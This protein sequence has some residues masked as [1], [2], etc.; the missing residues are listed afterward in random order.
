MLRDVAIDHVLHARGFAEALPRRQRVTPLIDGAAQLLGAFAR[1]GHAPFRPA[2]DVHPALPPGVAVIDGEA[3]RARGMDPHRKAD[4]LGV[5]N[6]IADAGPQF[7]IAQGFLIQFQSVDHVSGLL[8]PRH[9]RRSAPT[10]S[11]STGQRAEYRRKVELKRVGQ[12]RS[13]RSMGY[14]NAPS[15]RWIESEDRKGRAIDTKAAES[16]HSLRSALSPAVR[17]STP[18]TLHDQTAA[19]RALQTFTSSRVPAPENCQSR[20]SEIL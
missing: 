3:P 20:Q 1:S 4:H 19:S 6:L 7:G 8:F 12:F 11:Q 17:A 2:P 15:A 13:C 5:E 16:R 10:S 18:I 9:R 14:A